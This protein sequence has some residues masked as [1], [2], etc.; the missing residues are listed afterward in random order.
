MIGTLETWINTDYVT[1]LRR[2]SNEASRTL[3]KNSKGAE[4]EGHAQNA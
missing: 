1:V 4:K 3:R 2:G